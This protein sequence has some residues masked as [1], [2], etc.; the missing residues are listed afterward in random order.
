MI[1]SGET[2]RVERL[3]HG[4]HHLVLSRPKARNALDAVMIGELTRAL[5]TLPALPE[6]ELRLLVLRGEGEVFCSG[7]DLGYMRARPAR[8]SRR[9]APTPG[10][11]RASFGAW[12]RCRCPSSACCAARRWGA[13]SASWPAATS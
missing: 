5:D 12:R 6:P 2:L 9:T 11:C 10:S 8:Q 1:V 7:A 4:V 3:D 13:G